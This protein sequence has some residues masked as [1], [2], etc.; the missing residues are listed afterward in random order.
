MNSFSFLTN[1]Q[2]V[3][4]SQF[5]ESSKKV[6]NLCLMSVSKERRFFYLIRCIYFFHDQEMLRNYEHLPEHLLLFLL[7]Q[8]IRKFWK[9]CIHKLHV[10]YVHISCGTPLPVDLQDPF[11]S[12]HFTITDWI[13]F[14]LLLFKN[15]DH[16]WPINHTESKQGTARGIPMFYY[17]TNRNI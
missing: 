8:E 1:S 14:L 10:N 17:F 15:C 2:P 4:V 13:L 9:Y 16:Q 11:K 5:V 7:L 3:L 6:S 12:L